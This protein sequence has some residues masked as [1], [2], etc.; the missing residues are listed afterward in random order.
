MENLINK[1]PPNDLLML[2]GFIISLYEH[3]NALV[4][5]IN[6]LTTENDY[7]R[8]RKSLKIADDLGRLI[9]QNTHDVSQ[10]IGNKLLDSRERKLL[11]SEDNNTCTQLR[12]RLRQAFPGIAI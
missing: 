10:A 3:A 7:S 11:G 8:D 1:M 2:S 6:T 9:L 4:R 12:D 5:A